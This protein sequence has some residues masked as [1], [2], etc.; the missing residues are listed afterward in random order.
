MFHQNL[1]WS[2]AIPIDLAN[3]L[4]KPALA[5]SFKV[6][7]LPALYLVLYLIVHDLTTGFKVYDGLGKQAVALARLF[8]NLLCFLPG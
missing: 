1:L 6:K 3:Y 5:N 2:T 8:C 7:P 4:P